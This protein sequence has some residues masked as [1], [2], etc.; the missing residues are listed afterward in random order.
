MQ[1]GIT[2]V[3][4]RKWCNKEAQNSKVIRLIQKRKKIITQQKFSNTS[5]SVWGQFDLALIQNIIKGRPSTT[6]VVFCLRT[7]QW[8][9][10]YNANVST[11]VVDF[12]VTPCKEKKSE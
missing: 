12:I 6:T 4:V 8:L 3:S 10:T 9:L 7:E 1:L 5:T 2:F 11:R